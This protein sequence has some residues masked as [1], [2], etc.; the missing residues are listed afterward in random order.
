MELGDWSDYWTDER[1]I[2]GGVWE[3][4][5]LSEFQCKLRLCWDQ[6]FCWKRLRFVVGIVEE[7]M[8]IFKLALIKLIIHVSY[9]SLSLVKNTTTRERKIITSKHN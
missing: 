6:I 3:N 7:H 2:K 4:K 9:P 1:A 5:H 8:L